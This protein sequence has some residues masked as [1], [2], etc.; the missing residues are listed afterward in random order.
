YMYKII[1]IILVVILLLLGAGFAFSKYIGDI[2][3]VISNPRILETIENG[4][5]ES[6]TSGTLF[7]T[8]SLPF[9]LKVAGNFNVATYADGLGKVRDLAF[10]PE[11]I[12]LASV[13]S[14]GRVIA[15]VMGEDGAVSKKVV[16]DE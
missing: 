10:S 2:R 5:V 14:E 7:K 6:S 4:S 1:A 9:E 3:P 13:P 15:L 16:V 12:L 11:G 8:K